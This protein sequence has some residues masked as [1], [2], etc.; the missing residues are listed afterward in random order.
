MASF[1]DQLSSLVYSTDGGD[2]RGR[3]QDDNEDEAR[4]SALDGIVRL[5]R[6]TSGRKGKGVTTISGVPLPMAE[7][8]TL[9]QA[10]KK[11][12]G[13]GGTLTRQGMIEIQGDHREALKAEL[14]KRGFTVKLAGG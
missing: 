2:Q 5:R 6:E 9:T 4:L 13:S 3:Q 10:L 14:E 12:C 7:L 8:R 11:R 1:K